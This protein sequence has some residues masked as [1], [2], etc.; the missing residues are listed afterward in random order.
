MQVVVQINSCPGK[1]LCF[2]ILSQTFGY[3]SLPVRM[4][5]HPLTYVM[6]LL[7]DISD[8]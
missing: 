3:G 7:Q 4:I 8:I 6:L 1:L 5:L 2:E